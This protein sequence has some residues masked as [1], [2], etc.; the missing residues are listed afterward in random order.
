MRKFH[1][2]V[3]PWLVLPLVV[4]LITGVV[5]RIGRAWFGMGDGAG[6]ILMKIH[7][8]E[9]LGDAVSPVYVI[10]MGAFL[11][12]L[13]VTGG[14]LILK[15]KSR[16]GDRFVHRI[17]AFVLVLPLAASALTGIAYKVGDEWLEIP[18]AKLKI[19]MIIHEGAWLG[20][21]FKPFYVLFVGVGLLVLAFTGLRLAGFPRKPRP[22]A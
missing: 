9:W 3:A 8:G 11:L 12:A 19:F 13:V 4:T 1:R 10:V 16:K 14:V 6:D 22:A 15:G 5:F 21:T 7:A 17:L 2:L 18:D 20:K